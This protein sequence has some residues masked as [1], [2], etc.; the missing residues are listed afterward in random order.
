MQSLTQLR[1]FCS[2]TPIETMSVQAGDGLGDIGPSLS[3]HV[4]VCGVC[5]YV[6]CV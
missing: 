5:V 1:D 2:L 6:V 3:Q 4:C